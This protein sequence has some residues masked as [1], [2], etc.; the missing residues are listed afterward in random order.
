VHEYGWVGSLDQGIIYEIDSEEGEFTGREIDMVSPYGAALGP[1]GILWT[2][3]ASW[4][5]LAGIDTTT[6]DRVEVAFPAGESPYGITVDGDGRVWIGGSTARYDPST[7]EWESPDQNVWGGGI[8]VDGNGDAWTGEMG[9]AW[10]IDGETLEATSI[11]GSGGHG[12]AVDF[13]GYAWAIE[14]AGDA[15]V[16]DPETLEVDERVTGFVGPYTYSDMTGFQLVNATNPVGTFPHI[17]QACDGAE[18]VHWSRLTCDADVPAGTSI[19]FRGRIADSVELL[20]AAQWIDLGQLPTVECP[21][22]LDAV[23]ASAGLPIEAVSDHYFELEA[24]LASA[25]RDGRPTLNVMGLDY[26]CEDIFQ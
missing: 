25:N 23:F 17:F 2:F 15:T 1:G 24:T 9:S 5:G 21:I 10:H 4:G 18:S 14:W 22:D 16:V 11:P 6:L 8:A 7:E 3:T 26:S 20:A 13:D 12:W 19:S